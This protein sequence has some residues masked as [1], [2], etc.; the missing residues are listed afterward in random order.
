M[1]WILTIIVSIIGSV[2]L[3]VIANLITNPIKD[4][5]AKRSLISSIKRT[6]KLQTEFARVER[7][8]HNQRRFYSYMFQMV[9]LTLLSLYV[10]AVAIVVFLFVSLLD[11]AHDPTPVIMDLYPTK[12]YIQ[13]CAVLLF[14]FILLIGSYIVTE[15]I[16]LARKVG[17]FD[18]Y[19]LEFEA[20]I[21]KLTPRG[22][23]K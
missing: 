20:R 6:N 17:R 22:Q 4:W 14:A 1:N 15:T 11:Y 19:K 13:Y 21:A 3:S 12:V 8:Y 7:F 23:P 2:I 5:Y 10:M 16:E 9:M 18:E